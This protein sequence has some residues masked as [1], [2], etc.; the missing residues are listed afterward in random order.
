[1]VLIFMNIVQDLPDVSKRPAFS[2][3]ADLPLF[4]GTAIF[5]FEGISLVREL[6]LLLWKFVLAVFAFDDISLVENLCN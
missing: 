1:M 4:F 2:N 6:V 5:A 3:V